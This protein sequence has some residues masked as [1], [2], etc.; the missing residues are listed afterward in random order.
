[1][2]AE[3]CM[4]LQHK[5]IIMQTLIRSFVRDVVGCR[6]SDEEG[7]GGFRGLQ[8]TFIDSLA[9]YLEAL[10][11]EAVGTSGVDDEAIMKEIL[12]F[13]LQVISV[14]WGWGKLVEAS[15]G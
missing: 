6:M 15:E 11:A 3:T 2:P 9:E 12:S 14:E 5:D 10:L 13:K 1:M 8:C 4:C 7:Q